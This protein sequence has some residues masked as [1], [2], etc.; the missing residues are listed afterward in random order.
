ML[1][2]ERPDARNGT[3]TDHPHPANNIP[4]IRGVGEVED[5]SI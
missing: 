5:W 1:G 4:T 3:N 2:D